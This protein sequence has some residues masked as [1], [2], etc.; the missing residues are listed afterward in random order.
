[1]TASKYTT[2]P[3]T[4]RDKRGDKHIIAD[5]DSIMCDMSYYPW[6]PYNDADWHLIA[7]APEMYELIFDLL[8]TDNEFKTEWDIT[9]NKVLAKA[10]GES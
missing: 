10:R 4:V 7:A 6:A 5:G 1:M 8:E 9:A 3:W 2:G